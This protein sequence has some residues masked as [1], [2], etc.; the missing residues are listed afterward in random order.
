VHSKSAFGFVWAAVLL[1]GFV[2][3]ASAKKV[4]APKVTCE[5]FL[6]LSEDEK[7]RLVAY[8]DGRSKSGIEEKALTEVDVQRDMGLLVVACQEDPKATF[9]DKVQSKLPGGKHK[10]KTAKMTCETY[11]SVEKSSQPEVAYW[12][13]GYNKKGKVSADVVDEVNLETDFTFVVQECKA[14]PKVSIWEKLKKH[15]GH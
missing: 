3:A 1:L 2:P 13:A 14:A 8:L 4:N 10:V 6:A 7:P 11:A 5:E 12:L 9:W 15:F